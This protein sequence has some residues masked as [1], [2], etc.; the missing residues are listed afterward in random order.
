MTL[1]EYFGDWMKVI[2]RT[3]LSNVMD[4]V[5]QEYKR[6][7]LCPIQSDVFKA[8]ELCSLKDLKIVMLGQDP[9]PQKGVAT[10]ILFGNNKETSN[11]NLSSSLKVIKEAAIN[12]EVPHNCIIFDQTLES[13]ARQGLL[14]LN[15]ALTVEMNKVGSH[16]MLWRP[17]IAKLLK[18]L[19]EY[20]TA[21]IYI[22]FG[23]Q[24]QSF[25]PYINDK[26]NYVIEI[27]HPAYFARNGTKM[28]HKLF[29]DI[30]NK[31]KELYGVPVKWYEE[32]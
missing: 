4:K 9:Y 14:M 13:W 6:K 18:S 27:E 25:K 29:I 8:F 19:S 11:E 31:V 30:S 10:G 1:D 23:R 7:P 21:I 15:S 16:T 5:G 20:N 17:F 22:L 24:A 12:F 3:E 26:L 28:P 2:D 32:Y